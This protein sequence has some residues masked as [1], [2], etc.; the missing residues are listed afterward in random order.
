MQPD[1]RRTPAARLV[2]RHRFRAVRGS[3]P[4]LSAWWRFA[5]VLFFLIGG[6]V[7]AQ[8][9]DPPPAP[10][11]TNLRAA[12]MYGNVVLT[13][14]AAVAPGGLV[15][16]YQI[17]RRYVPSPGYG[18]FRVIATT[19][20]TATTYEDESVGFGGRYIFRV[21]AMY[22][23]V[24]SRWSKW[25]RAY[26]PE[27][28]AAPEGLVAMEGDG[29]VRLTW[30]DPGDN[31][32]TGYE[33]RYGESGTALPAWSADHDI[34]SGAGTTTH[35]VPG[36][37]N[38][39]EYTFE[40]RPRNAS[41]YFGSSRVTATPEARRPAAPDILRTFALDRKVTVIWARAEDRRI[42]GYQ[43]RYGANGAWDPDW[44]HME[45]SSFG[46]TGNTPRGLTNGI[47]YTIEVRAMIGDVEGFSS[48]VMAVPVPRAPRLV[49]DPVAGDREVT[50]TWNNLVDAAV[51]RYE[52]RYGVGEAPAEWSVISVRPESGAST[53]TRT[54]PGLTNGIEYTFEV[55]AFAGEYPGASASVTATPVAPPAAPDIRRTFALDRKVTVIWARAEDR[56]ITGYQI[57]Y[58]A[59]GAWDPDWTAIDPS[60]PNTTGHT[61]G[62]LTNGI[63][64]TIEVRAVA[65]DYPGASSSVMATP[66]AVP[67]PA[68][69]NLTA[70]ED[71]R[72]V[73]LTWDNLDTPD[74]T[75]YEIRYGVGEA[76]A[77]WTVISVS[78]VSDASTT[79]HP[80]PGLTNGIV[81]TFEVRAVA[82]AYPGVSASVTVMLEAPP[83]APGN[84]T[85]LPGDRAV[86]LT[87]DNLDAPAVARYEIRYGVGE[88]PAAWTVI[89]VRPVSDASTTTR[90]VPG[91]TN[92]I[93][94][95]FE[96]RAIRGSVPGMPARVTATPDLPPPRRLR[97][98][99]FCGGGRTLTRQVS[100]T[101]SAPRALRK[102]RTSTPARRRDTAT[103]TG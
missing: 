44:M 67:P 90:E 99:R 97:A 103:C 30:N 16:G 65:G 98:T 25:A 9:D 42:T 80:V 73:T 84:L 75:G 62:N 33:V 77:A 83:A 54:V 4:R 92:G 85:A 48:S 6:P 69:G 71:D 94:Y 49:G 59:N 79:T 28:P 102:P 56:R 60:G 41:G 52:I 15:T 29:M 11:P 57:R 43:I 81:Y 61:V 21:K 86:T 66:G 26:V 91:L 89:S 64:Y 50:L 78:P 93:E 27:P 74:V 22:G 34:D 36:L 76:P 32:L 87:W 53:T 1:R 39:V 88:V 38:G 31:T 10:P 5:P 95:T 51:A 70:R 18:V 96:V 55:R 12:V 46:T 23:D 47:K 13:W 8:G 72:A 14:D 3:I 19:G 35:P 40:V 58:G 7:F 37:T 20:P 2:F 45:R 82:G 24:L 68:P 101:R 17:L 100:L 63:E